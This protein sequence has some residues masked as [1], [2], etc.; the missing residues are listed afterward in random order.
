MTE[1]TTHKF[2]TNELHERYGIGRSVVYTRINALS[3]KP[4]RQGIKSY[5]TDVQLQMMDDLNAH[6]KDGGRTDD[7]VRQCIADG[8]I[9][10]SEPV[11]EPTIFQRLQAQMIASL[12]QKLQP[13]TT[14]ETALS[15]NSGRMI[16]EL[17]A[18]IGEQVQ[19]NDPQEV[20]ERAQRRAFANIIEEETLTLFYEVTEE[21]TIP[22]LKEQL[23]Q[24][25]AACKQARSKSIVYNF[26]D[27]LSSL[28]FPMR[29]VMTNDS[30]SPNTKV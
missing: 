7:F 4:H 21:F 17:E 25:R 22:G 18:I 11:T 8:S 5:I 29:A 3:I 12:S 13:S 27:F 1:D 24:Y 28:G 14:E 30:T 19:P 2:P 10:L 15:V 6:L 20:H 23:E 26:D 16:A 9:V